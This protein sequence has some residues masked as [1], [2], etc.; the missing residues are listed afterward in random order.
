MRSLFV[1]FGLGATA[2]ALAGGLIEFGRLLDDL[3]ADD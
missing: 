1:G 2:A 3:Y